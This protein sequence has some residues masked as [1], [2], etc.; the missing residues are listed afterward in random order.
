MRGGTSGQR[1]GS[2]G[3]WDR[4]LASLRLEA[5]ALGGG[6]RLPRAAG[7]GGAGGWGRGVRAH[8]RRVL[9]T[10]QL[11]SACLSLTLRL[12][13]RGCAAKPR[14]TRG[15]GTPTQRPSRYPALAPAGGRVFMTLS[16][17]SGTRKGTPSIQ[18][19]AD[20]PGRRG[21]ATLPGAAPPLCAEERSSRAS[22]THL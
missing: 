17:S 1:A 19:R 9:S 7:G 15:A 16:R 4:P 3:S 2:S 21:G 13:G 8:I 12:P 5:G 22:R 10:W 18:P 20:G 6:S 14:P 11:H